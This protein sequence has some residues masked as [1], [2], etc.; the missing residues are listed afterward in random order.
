MKFALTET[1]EAPEGYNISVD[2]ATGEVSV[3]FPRDAA[4]NTDIEVPVRVTYRDGT[5][6]TGT[7]YFRL[8]KQQDDEVTVPEE[9]LSQQ[10]EYE[11]TYAVTW[12]RAGQNATSVKPLFTR[13]LSG[14]SFER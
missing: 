14:H 1:F 13:T 10:D 8:D 4:T 6:A 12:G 11:P 5:T 2:E 3:A 7:A 9:Q